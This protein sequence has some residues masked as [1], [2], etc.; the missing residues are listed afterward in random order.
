MRKRLLG[1]PLVLMVTACQVNLPGFWSETRL[2]G[3]R[4]GQAVAPVGTVPVAAPPKAAAGASTPAT[5]AGAGTTAD[6]EP[7]DAEPSLD[8]AAALLAFKSYVDSYRAKDATKV[9]SFESVM[10]AAKRHVDLETE[11]Q[12]QWSLERGHAEIFIKGQDFKLTTA[13]FSQIAIA[14]EGSQVTLTTKDGSPLLSASYNLDGKAGTH[15][16]G[17]LILNRGV[18]GKMS[19]AALP[20][21]AAPEP[22]KPIVEAEVDLDAAWP[23]PDGPIVTGFEREAAIDVVEALNAAYARRDANAVA[24]LL[25]EP[26]TGKDEWK[27]KLVKDLADPL[28]SVRPM[29]RELLTVVKVGSEWEVVGP[30]AVIVSFPLSKGGTVTLTRHGAIRVKKDGNRLVVA[31]TCDEP[32]DCE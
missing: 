7:T 1:L 22:P 21:E 11:G 10:L 2:Q 29:A 19:F 30:Q 24:M 3:T 20:F 28:Y 4:E 26:A 18:D 15:V 17:K 25:P 16:V 32:G 14:H 31:K 8:N 12:F 6:P 13:D 5:T 9:A 23:I 27:A